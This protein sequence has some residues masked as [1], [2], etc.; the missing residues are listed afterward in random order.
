MVINSCEVDGGTLSGIGTRNT[1]AAGL[2]SANTQ[3]HARRKEFHFVF[4]CDVPADQS[5]SNYTAKSL[6]RK[7]AINRKTEFAL[8]IFSGKLPRLL[9]QNISQLIEACASL[10]ADRHDRGVFQKTAAKEIFELQANQIERIAI[11]KVR[12]CEDHNSP[13]NPE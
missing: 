10:R 7:R 3:F 12:F 13:L 6:H 9:Q 1:L 11:D 5:S 2:H 8:R 4:R